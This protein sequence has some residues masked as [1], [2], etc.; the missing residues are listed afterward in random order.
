[1]VA[2]TCVF[3][4]VPD[5]V[6]GLQEIRRVVK[7]DGRVILLEHMRHD[8]KVLGALMDCINPVVVQIMGPSINRRTLDNISKAGMEV[9]TVENLAMGGILKFIVARPG[10]EASQSPQVADGEARISD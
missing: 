6:L 10:K 7:P 2:A 4:S 8:N 9:E 5:P 1:T 3:C